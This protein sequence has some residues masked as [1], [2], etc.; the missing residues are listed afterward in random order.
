MKSNVSLGYKHS[1]Q[2]FT[3][4]FIKLSK[5]SNQTRYVN[6]IGDNGKVQISLCNLSDKNL[7]CTHAAF[8]N[9][10]LSWQ[11]TLSYWIDPH[12]DL[13]L[14]WLEKANER[15]SHGRDHE[16]VHKN[17]WSLITG[18]RF[19]CKGGNSVKYTLPPFSTGST[20]SGK[21][22]LLW[23]SFLPSWHRPHF[24]MASVYKNANRKS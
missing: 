23:S 11:A 22:L 21:N 15:L 4:L 5:L 16:K 24:Q 7:P 14:P 8:K 13:Y 6:L 12:V 1:P 3:E 10:R 19:I 17:E 18:N 2:L 20:L 9:P